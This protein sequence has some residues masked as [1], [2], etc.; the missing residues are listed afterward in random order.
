MQFKPVLTPTG[1]GK[2]VIVLTINVSTEI[3]I[4]LYTR[5]LYPVMLG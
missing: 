1:L 2:S 4:E 3:G 5:N